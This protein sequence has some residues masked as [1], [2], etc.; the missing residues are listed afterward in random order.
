VWNVLEHNEKWM[1]REAPPKKGSSITLDDLEDSDDAKSGRNKGKSD[2]RRM[3]ED[4]A[5]R[6]MRKHIGELVKLTKTIMTK[7]MKTK[8]A[9]IEK[10]H[11]LKESKLEPV[12]LNEGKTRSQGDQGEGRGGQGEGQ[13]Y[14]RG[15]SNHDNGSYWDGCSC[16]RVLGDAKIGDHATNKTRVF[17]P[18]WPMLMLLWITSRK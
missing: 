9:L 14:R 7:H 12:W 2:R 5:R 11:Q 3:E 13:G 18:L 15:R 6:K 8:M 16:Q 10:K 4:K 17:L 1:D